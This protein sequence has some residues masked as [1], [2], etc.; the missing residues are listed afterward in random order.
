[1]TPS[2]RAR[3]AAAARRFLAAEPWKAVTDAHLFGLQDRTGGQFGCASVMG[4]AGME[5]GLSVALGAE[6]FSLFQKL[7]ADELDLSLMK[8][9]ANCVSFKIS[10][11]APASRAFERLRPLLVDA[12]KVKAPARGYLTGWRLLSGREPTGLDEEGALFLA[13]CLEAVAELAETG[14]LGRDSLHDGA[15]TLF[16]DLIEEGGAL[17]LVQNYRQVEEVDVQHPPVKLPAP[18]LEVLK[19]RPRV[20]ARY[21]ATVFS[22]PCTIQ[23]KPV[24]TALLLDEQGFAVPAGVSH[25]FGEAALGIFEVLA[26]KAKDERPSLGIPRELW[27]D[28]YSVFAALKDAMLELEISFLSREGLPELEDVKA[29][30]SDAMSY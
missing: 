24:W 26:G 30:L 11:A 16:Y 1:M 20:D 15:R 5:Y 6:G 22:P 3:L 10:N 18:L 4:G 19:G 25:D 7:Q 2:T 8:V 21:L 28:S 12:A 13:R 14:R 29:S 23:G 9:K 17:R 27:T